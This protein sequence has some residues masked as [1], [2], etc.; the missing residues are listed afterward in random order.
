MTPIWGGG[1]AWG[2]VTGKPAFGTAALKDTGT[3]SGT[4]PL[5]GAGDK[6]ASALMPAIT[7]NQSYSV[8]SQAAMLALTC[9]EGD[10]AMRTDLGKTFILTGADPS[11]LGNWTE[12]QYPADLVTSVEGDTGDVVLN[13]HLRVNLTDPQ[14][15]YT[16]DAEVCLIPAADAA[17]TITAIRVTCDGN[18]ATEFDCDL[19]W[20]DDFVTRANATKL[21]DITTVDGKLSSTGLALA[22]A[23]GKALYLVLSDPDDA[24]TQVNLDFTYDYD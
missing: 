24:I 18:P 22:L 13:R 14:A 19:Y 8:A 11:V 12:W 17:L 7:I 23:S 20:A 4:V 10:F 2:D 5:V 21:A 16:N 9:E 3:T 15:L 6:L 1:V